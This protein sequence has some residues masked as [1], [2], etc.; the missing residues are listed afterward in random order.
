MQTHMLWVYGEF[1][2]LEYLC[3]ASFIK[4]GYELNVWSYGPMKN[5]P[6]GAHLCDAREILPEGQVF[7]NSK[8]SYAAFS[9]IFRYA[10]LIKRGGLYVDTDVVALQPPGQLPKT[11]FL[12]SEYTLTEGAVGGQCINGNVMFCP[13]PEPGDLLDLAFIISSKFPREK[14]IWSEIGPHLLTSLIKLMP[15][16]G[17]YIAPPQF[18]NPF[19]YWDCPNNLLA[20]RFNIWEGTCFVHLYTSEWKKK[21]ID[22]EADFPEGSIMSEIQRLFCPI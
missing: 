14:I 16:H 19:K 10:V 3:A 2:R 22:K 5:L 9:D 13:D 15:T 20:S 12:V 8:G 18:A 4:L 6:A 7:L 21:G 11:R 17:F 1:G